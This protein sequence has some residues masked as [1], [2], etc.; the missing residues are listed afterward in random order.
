MAVH[1]LARYRR[2]HPV[3]LSTRR[4]LLAPLRQWRAHCLVRRHGPSLDYT[5]AWA[6][7]TLQCS[8]HEF[9]FVQQ[10]TH[11]AGSTARAGLYYDD[12]NSLGPRERAR[13]TRWLARHDKTPV[14][15]LEITEEQ[16]RRAGLRVVDWGNP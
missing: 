8:P 14:Q 12:W 9:P 6:L 3:N 4:W 11:E 1:R 13:R 5:T 16:L 15:R 7:I 10:A 2:R